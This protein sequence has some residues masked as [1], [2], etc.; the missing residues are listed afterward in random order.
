M[1]NVSDADTN[2]LFRNS[3]T[4]EAQGQGPPSAW[5]THAS[6][7]N[8]SSTWGHNSYGQNSQDPTS[9]LRTTST[10]HNLHSQN[11]HGYHLPDQEVNLGTPPSHSTGRDQS[12]IASPLSPSS[13]WSDFGVNGG[14]VTR[15]SY[16]R[17]NNGY[18]KQPPNLSTLTASFAPPASLTSDGIDNHVRIQGD[19]GV[20]SFSHPHAHLQDDG[21]PWSQ[22]HSMAEPC[23]ANARLSS[24]REEPLHTMGVGLSG[25]DG[26]ARQN[27]T[28][29][30]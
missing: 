21:R 18:E 9:Q 3:L 24:S 19:P 11:T 5:S 26:M 10:N 14:L 7:F 12:D 1:D 15:P 30:W 20:T 4:D 13:S 29:P 8:E 16:S 23:A 6:A 28:R 17:G 22:G 2:F 25:D 27:P